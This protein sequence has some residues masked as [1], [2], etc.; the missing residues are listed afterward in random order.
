[1]GDAQK[2]SQPHADAA[3]PFHSVGGKRAERIAALAM[4]AVFLACFFAWRLPADEPPALPSAPKS[5]SELHSRISFVR[6]TN[7]PDGALEIVLDEATPIYEADVLVDLGETTLLIAEGL[8]KFFPGVRSSKVRVTARL[9]TKSPERFATQERVLEL[10]WFRA[11]ILKVHNG[12]A[13]SF[14]ELLN[15]SQSTTY[16]APTSRWLVQAFCEDPLAE[17]A[18]A[19]CRRELG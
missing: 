3:W 18:K 8:Q 15:L 13:A 16:L 14:Q 2:K 4:A 9:P 7:G 19:F 12:G 6:E 11:D 17:T 1:M 10:T 5:I